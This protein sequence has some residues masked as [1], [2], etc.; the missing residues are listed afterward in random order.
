M[1]RRGWEKKKEEKR[2][3]ITQ[4]FIYILSIIG[5]KNFFIKNNK[6]AHGVHKAKAAVPSSRSVVL[7]KTHRTTYTIL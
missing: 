5:E 4:F 1:H 3:S 6:K 7:F 2:E